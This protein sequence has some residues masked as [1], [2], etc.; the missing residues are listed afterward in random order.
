LLNSVGLFNSQTGNAM[1]ISEIYVDPSIAA[2]SGTGAISDPF[3]D[4]E[5]AIVQTTFDTTN[6]TR[7]NIKAGTEEVLAATLKTSLA[8]TSVSAAWIT[9]TAAR[10]VFRGYT[11]A[12]GDGG[13][14]SISGGGSVTIL[15][16][17]AG[18]NYTSFIDLKLHNTGAYAS[19]AMNDY[20]NLIRC[21]IHNTQGCYLGDYSRI[22]GCHIYDTGAPA[23]RV[24]DYGLIAFNVIDT[25]TGT[26]TA[27]RAIE[28]YGAGNTVYR[29]IIKVDGGTA[30]ILCNRSSYFLNN[31]I[32][33]AGGTGS[34]FS[35]VGAN[36]GG[37]V[38]MSN[39][40]EGF[41]GSGGVGFNF[42]TS[43]TSLAVYSG[44]SAYNND[45]NY[46]A[47]ALFTEFDDFGDNEALAASPFT[48]PANM[49]FSPIDTGSVKEGSAPNAFLSV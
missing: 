13:I 45:T 23:A 1:A 49:D 34:G 40:V 22:M 9:S 24:E 42:G 26:H 14:G 41:S 38:V 19:I 18:R 4:L 39:I 25:V 3:G 30:G 36:S 21:E 31:S 17:A 10:L 7:V 37:L 47:P 20:C 12:A 8:D 46:V 5:Y 28:L 48:D 32:Y 35:N 6:G 15:T 29:N 33:S 27:S 43:G 44:N 11:A 16:D 2:D